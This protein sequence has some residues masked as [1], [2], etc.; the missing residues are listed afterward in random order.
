MVGEQ[1]T[2]Q[3]QIL[4]C[5]GGLALDQHGVCGNAVFKGVLP[6]MNGLAARKSLDRRRRVGAREDNEWK[7]SLVEQVYGDDR[8]ARIMAAE[9]DPHVAWPRCVPHIVVLPQ[10]LHVVAEIFGDGRLGQLWSLS[11]DVVHVVRT[12][13]AGRYAGKPAVRRFAAG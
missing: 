2:G 5:V 1:F 9:P 3:G 8:D 11:S 10:R 12:V 7:H 6:I 4:R 13:A